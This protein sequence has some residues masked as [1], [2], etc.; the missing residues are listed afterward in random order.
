M[1]EELNPA[2]VLIAAVNNTFAVCG[3]KQTE[4]IKS[5]LPAMATEIGQLIK[6]GEGYQFIG[7]AV[8]FSEKGA[9]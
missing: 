6:Y 4:L 1:T 7:V 8:T 9:R 3:P 5:V 2:E